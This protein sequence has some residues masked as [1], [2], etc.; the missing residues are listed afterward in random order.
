MFGFLFYAGM[1]FA[2]QRSDGSEGKA[3]QD[4]TQIKEKHQ[5]C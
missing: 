2:G 1:C 3:C 4:T 5:I